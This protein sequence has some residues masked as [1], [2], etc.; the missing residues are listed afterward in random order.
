MKAA[1][2][3]RNIGGFKGIKRFEF[4]EGMVNEVVAGNAMGKTSITRGLGAVLSGRLTHDE[5]IREGMNQGVSRESLKNIYEKDAAVLLSYNGKEREWYMKSDGSFG[6][7]E[8]DQ[9]FLLTGMLTQEAR[10]IRQLIEGDSDF[11]WVTRLLSY[12]QRYAVAK[13]F[14]DSKLT[15]AEQEVERIVR[16]QETLVEQDKRLQA[17]KE[18]KAKLDQERDQLGE[19]LDQQKREHIEK[20]K[21][22]E[23]DIDLRRERIAQYHGSISKSEQNI[24]YLEG[25]LGSSERNLREV[26]R[27]LESIDLDTIRKQARQNVPVIDDKIGHL[28]SEVATLNSKR[29]T[30]AD[31]KNVLAQRGEEE[32]L[33]PVCEVSTITSSLLNEKILELNSSIQD[34]QGKIQALASERTRELQKEATAIRQI[35]ALNKV[36]INVQSEKRELELRKSTETKTL[37]ETKKALAEIERER[38]DLNTEKMNL[39]RETEQWEAE[40]HNA[41]Q[42]IERSIEAVANEI[43]HQTEKIRESSLVDIRERRLS[44]EE[45]QNIW[46]QL[47]DELRDMREYLDQ[48]QHDHEVRA[49]AD[50]NNAVKKVMTDL[51]FSEFDQIAID[52]D[53]KQL[54]VFRPGFVRQ[55][56]ESLSTSEKY[57]LAVVLQ[58]ALKETYVPDI[59][60]FVVDEVMVSYDGT[61]TRKILEYLERIARERGLYVIVTRLAEKGEGEIAVKAR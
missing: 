2:E 34:K 35:D 56:V 11:S 3:L 22:L 31:A 54:K 58:I 60:F 53:D 13:A 16:R 46:H 57:S 38:A 36:I 10:S 43:G 49:V 47:Q 51:G 12:A 42:S 27:Q 28:R 24:K 52:K 26:K 23:H 18:E 25:R 33:C 4:E 1:L 29:A 45:A 21:T 5:I 59:P 8:G 19:K 17:K 44:F 50:F 6:A 15:N 55:P 40:I 39:Q 37:G 9:R 20:I 48:R 7:T 41:L 61:K 14:I 32:G 30:F